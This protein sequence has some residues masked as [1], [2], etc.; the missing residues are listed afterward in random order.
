[1]QLAIKLPSYPGGSFEVQDMASGHTLRW[2][3]T[4]ELACIEAADFVRMHGGGG[5]FVPL[6]AALPA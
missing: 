3:P 5:V 1:M 6:S 4:F 2:A